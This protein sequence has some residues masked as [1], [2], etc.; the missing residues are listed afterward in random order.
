MANEDTTDIGEEVDAE[1]D[2][3]I[4][5]GLGGYQ[6]AAGLGADIEADLAAGGPITRYMVDVRGRAI[7]AIKRFSGLDLEDDKAAA[8]DC[9]AAV[10]AYLALMTWMAANL[11]DAERASEVIR[12]HL[13]PEHEGN[14][15]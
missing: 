6:E 12:R 7:K 2:V 1:I 8:R 10:R 5:E 13:A 4:L 3:A 9:Q 14:P 11:A 15:D